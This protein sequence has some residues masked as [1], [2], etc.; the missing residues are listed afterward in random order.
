MSGLQCQGLFAAVRERPAAP[1]ACSKSLA[2]CP[3]LDRQIVSRATAGRDLVGQPG[4][5]AV[6][7]RPSAAQR[8]QQR[9]N[10]RVPR[11][12]AF[13]DR[14]LGAFLTQCLRRVHANPT[15]H[16]A[17]RRASKEEGLH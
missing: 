12:S 9:A 16:E 1:Q 3:F 7:Q 17:G 2:S 4:P 14:A 6:V 11:R 10:A 15:G 5:L 13:L 8:Q